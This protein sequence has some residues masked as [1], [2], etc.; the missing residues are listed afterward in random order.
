[1]SEFGAALRLQGAIGVQ[2]ALGIQRAIGRDLA[3]GLVLA[4][5]STAPA[6]VAA[7]PK[8]PG[9]D[10]VVTAA[11]DRYRADGLHRWLLGSHHRDLWA[12]PVR[13]EILAL[14]EMAGGLIPLK[15]G[16]GMQ[17]R[18]LRFLGADGRE[19]TFR[20]VDKDPSA[21]LD[22][23]FHGTV[24]A[25]VVQDGIS[26]AH[27]FGALVAAPLLEA[28]GVLHVEPRLRV[29][30]DD[31]ALGAFRD[32]FAGML[33]LIEERPDENEEGPSAFA[34]A[35]KIIGSEKLTERLDEGPDDRVDA[36]AYLKARLMDVFL[37][38]WDRHRGQWRWATFDEEGPRRWQPIPRDRDQAFSD[39][40]G[41]ATEVAS[42]YA[43]QLVEFGP[44]YPSIVRLHW[45]ARAIDRWLLA[46][47][48]RE[49]WD[50]VGE[51]VRQ[52]LTD[53]VIDRAVRRLPPE[54]HAIDGAELAATLKARR[55]RLPSAWT[56]FYRLLAQQVDVRATDVDEIVRVHRGDD[57]SVE[58]TVA[59]SRTAAPWFRR[60]FLPDE[61]KELRIHLRDGDDEVLVSGDARVGIDVHIVGGRG[62]DRY[63]VHGRGDGISLYDHEGDD[64]TVGAGAPPLDRRP[65]DEWSWA[66]DDK[67]Q[68]RD[69]GRRTLPSF[70][71]SYTSDMG[72]FLGA[73]ARVE[74]YGFRNLPY[75]SAFEL[76]GG[77]TPTLGKGRLELEGIVNRPGSSL[78]WTVDAR[79]SGLDVLHYYG[80]G[81]RTAP[82]DE[83]F[84]RVDLARMSASVGVGVSPEPWLR[85]SADL[86]VRRSST[87]DDDRFFSTLGS[88]YGD[89]DFTTLGIGGRLVF[90]PLRDD[91]RAGHR[92]K[93]TLDGVVHP[94]VFDAENAFGRAGGDV[95]ALI[96][97]SPR[98]AL[99]LAVRV[100]AR[101]VFG[102]FPWHEAAFVGGG[103]TVRGFS[104]QRF[105][106]DAAAYASGELRVR[107]ARPTLVVPADLGFFG[108]GDTGRVWV[109]EASPG[110]WHTGV[111]G[112]LYLQPVGQPY[113]ARLGAAGSRESTKLFV[114]L[115]LP[116]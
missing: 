66:P 59:T 46:E 45:N 42:L 94:A 91:G 109:D 86:R 15:T 67:D 93:L 104:D 81:N 47:L 40:D 54:I 71:S 80:L 76:R 38:D 11:G 102:R 1:M 98:P 77:F 32:E 25:D 68:P 28:V 103:E 2:R 7:Q 96:A 64:V 56:D 34:G 82:G 107:V 41:A 30:P 48:D 33:G 58:V 95:S 116:Y 17:T 31:P 69:W 16:G 97:S 50:A 83:D 35:H 49:A 21:I 74:R 88:L 37:G 18:S 87:R 53:D 39:F 26:A 75:A 52:A 115:G 44:E 111:G 5:A 60:R 99:S 27:P 110:G 101:Q 8:E 19:Y 78:F 65:F 36:R 63:I 72:P 105:A 73:G 12:E 92:F 14:D 84:H 29:M 20:S 9:A 112:G 13:V 85:L 23:I 108:F 24:L 61:T 106:G 6:P 79:L 62:D 51:D 22:S 57:G 55:D 113:L 43:P 89:S 100:G 4:T 114:T 90:D 70:W 3:L 10:V